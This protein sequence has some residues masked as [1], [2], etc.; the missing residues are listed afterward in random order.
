[1]IHCRQAFYDLIQ[2]LDSKSGLL[3]SPPGIIHFFSG[4]KEDAAKLLELGFYFT[5]G[6]VITFSRDYDEVIKSTPSD[7]ILV[8]TDAPY[9]AP[10]PYRGKRNAPLFVIEVVKKIAELQNLNFEQTRELILQ[11]TKNI[12]SI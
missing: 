10:L 4:T 9:V 12:L 8:E 2:A 1:M 7:R 11:N 3:N 6:G 5:F